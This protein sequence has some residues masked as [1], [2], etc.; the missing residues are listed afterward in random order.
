MRF[1]KEIG[2]VPIKLETAFVGFVMSGPK[3]YKL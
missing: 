3:Q 1:I 2:L